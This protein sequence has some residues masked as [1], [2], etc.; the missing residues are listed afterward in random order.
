MSKEGRKTISDKLMHL[1]VHIY[2]YMS[3]NLFHI[4]AGVC[5]Y[6]YMYMCIYIHVFIYTY[7]YIVR[8][9]VYIHTDVF[10]YIYV[11]VYTHLYIYIYVH[12]Q[13]LQGDKE[14][15]EANPEGL[16][17]FFLSRFVFVKRKGT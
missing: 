15:T 4:F 8:H 3:K 16:V 12:L 5:I 17:L 13:P 14:S 2:I 6:I 9:V 7:I 10:I 11:C 1:C